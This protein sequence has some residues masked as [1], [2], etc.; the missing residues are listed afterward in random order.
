MPNIMRTTYPLI[1]LLL[2]GAAACE[3]DQ[4]LT[5]T[6]NLN[7]PGPLALV[8]AGELALSAARR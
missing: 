5:T 1:L 3:E 7:R 8:C 4:V 6:R 2:L